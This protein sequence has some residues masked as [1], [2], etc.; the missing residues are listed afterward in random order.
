M[1]NNIHILLVD[2]DPLLRRLFG[3]KLTE[4]GYEV[5]YASNGNDAREITRRL[6]PDLILM[7][8]KMPGLEDGFAI[9]ERLK[10]ED[11]TKD[12]PII[13]LSNND[14][15]FDAE[16]ILK[17]TTAVDFIHKSIDLDEFS[18]KIRAFFQKRDQQEN[19]G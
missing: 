12:I 13:F 1:P 11:I 2:D 15:S 6:K 19:N 17:K 14:L 8:I 4:I 3:G 16:T 7:D 10:S 18:E 5:I 9:A